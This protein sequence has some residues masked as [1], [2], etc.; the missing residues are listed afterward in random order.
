MSETGETRI[1]ETHWDTYV[2]IAR[3]DA[4]HDGLDIAERAPRDRASS[5]LA[6]STV[7]AAEGTMICELH[8]YDYRQEHLRYAAWIGDDWYLMADIADALAFLDPGGIERRAAKWAEAEARIAAQR[9]AHE[10][11]EQ[12]RNG[13]DHGVPV[14]TEGLHR[15]PG[16]R[17]LYVLKTTPRQL[18]Y[19]FARPEEVAAFESAESPSVAA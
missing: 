9:E 10:F 19:R 5:G 8:R 7:P 1:V 2:R 14:G 3:Y 15:R 18:R 6:A 4:V 16:G 12:V 11:R 13:A 17:L